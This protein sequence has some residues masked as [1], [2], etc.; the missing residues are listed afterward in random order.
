MMTEPS[1]TK[2]DKIAAKN[3]DAPKRNAAETKLRILRA[4]EAEFAAKG[5]DGARLGN[6]ARAASVQQALIHHYFAD[7]AGLYRDV[8]GRALEAMTMESLGILSGLSEKADNH[9][10]GRSRAAAEEVH[11]LV[12]AFVDLLLRFYSTHGAIMAILRHEAQGGGTIAADVVA[13]QVRPVAEAVT[14][15]IDSMRAAGEI[16]ADVEPMHL[17]VSA[18]AMAAFPFQE[19]PFLAATFPGKWGK[20]MPMAERKREIVATILRRMMP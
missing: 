11:D 19:E 1:R 13:V 14:A 8:I 12:E 20:A 15:K 10:E 6:I 16:R 9:H 18:V 7:K 5:F 17:C 2:L 4:A 3:E